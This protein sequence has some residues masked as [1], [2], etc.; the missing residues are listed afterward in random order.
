MQNSV[1]PHSKLGLPVPNGYEGDK[2]FLRDV[3]KDKDL[4]NELESSATNQDKKQ[5]ENHFNN[6]D[7]ANNKKID[8]LRNAE[9]KPSEEDNKFAQNQDEENKSL[10]S[11]NDKDN[12]DKTDQES[13]AETSDENGYDKESD[14]YEKSPEEKIQPESGVAEETAEG[15]SKLA[16]AGEV[17][18][19]A[20]SAAAVGETA[21]A[22]G[23]TAAVAEG[24]AGA[25][26]GAAIASSSPI[27]IPV[28]IVGI[29]I[30]II[31]TIAVSVNFLGKN[32]HRDISQTG[33]RGNVSYV[34]S[35]NSLESLKKLLNE[36]TD[37]FIAKIEKIKT[38]QQAQSKPN[39]E[40]IGL[41]DQIVAKAKELKDKNK[42]IKLLD[43]N[44]NSAD[45]ENVAKLKGEAEKLTIEIM[46][47]LKKLLTLVRNPVSVALLEVGTCEKTASFRNKPYNINDSW[48]AAFVEYVYKQAGLSIPEKEYLAPTLYCKMQKD[49]SKYITFEAGKGTPQPGDIVFFGWGDVSGGFC[50][51][52]IGHVGIVYKVNS[53][54]EITTIEGNTSVA[55]YST[56]C[57]GIKTRNI[58]T[59]YGGSGARYFARV[60]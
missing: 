9:K 59:T 44:P 38:Y 22:A 35:N 31:V 1:Y 57:V 7:K 43:T 55:G 40:A 13:E 3:Y 46:D 19:G 10:E 27:I 34:V 17:A 12:L 51:A 49:P 23:G 54:K 6:L 39:Q 4:R 26:A 60:K 56:D 58:N 48:C 14:S 30:I 29:I 24:T 52:E 53:D 33:D 2:N 8:G 16:G 32:D 41:C 37:S 45:R 28:I 15:A 36:N 25:A 18:T 20:G 5:L 47:L 11:E 21:V 42:E 50:N